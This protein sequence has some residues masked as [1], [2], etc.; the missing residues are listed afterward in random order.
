VHEYDV[1]GTHCKDQTGSEA[2]NVHANTTCAVPTQL[3]KS[4]IRAKHSNV[5]LQQLNL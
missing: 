2:K 4:N 3:L 5:A 1:T